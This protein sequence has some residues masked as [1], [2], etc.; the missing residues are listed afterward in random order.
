MSKDLDSLLKELASQDQFSVSKYFADLTDADLDI[1]IRNCD[2]IP[3]D[4]QQPF[5][6]AIRK[7]GV[8]DFQFKWVQ[9][10]FRPIDELTIYRFIDRIRA[11]TCPF[12]KRESNLQAECTY[13]VVSYIINSK[14]KV[15]SYFGC[16]ECIKTE[17]LAAYGLN[18]T[19]GWWSIKGLILNPLSYYFMIRRSNDEKRS[20]VYMKE[21]ILELKTAL[22]S[23][24]EADELNKLLEIHNK[25]QEKN[26]FQRVYLNTLVKIFR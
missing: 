4:F 23:L 16:K 5:L 3:G 12:C 20:E 25:S 18:M 24:K 19:L 8:S 6:H 11:S 17:R 2:N 22:L 15:N 10:T 7:R 14:V 21:W 1:L 9:D 13:Q 26:K